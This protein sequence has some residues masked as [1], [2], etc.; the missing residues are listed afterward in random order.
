MKFPNSYCKQDQ[1]E[2]DTVLV[3]SEKIAVS[4]SDGPGSWGRNSIEYPATVEGLSN[5]YDSAAD[6]FSRWLAAR[7]YRI[8][9]AAGLF[10]GLGLGL[11]LG[12]K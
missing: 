7:E 4:V 9:N 8:V 5:A 11:L 10:L 2:I 6:L 3:E 12:P 1:A